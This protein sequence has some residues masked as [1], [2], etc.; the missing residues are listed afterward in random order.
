MSW[1]LPF[2]WP[3]WRA[4]LRKAPVL[5]SLTQDE[6]K[7]IPT[8]H[9][10]VFSYGSLRLLGQGNIGNP[11]LRSSGNHLWLPAWE[12]RGR[13]ARPAGG[14]GR[15]CLGPWTA[16]LRR[17]V[18]VFSGREK[19]SCFRVWGANMSMNTAISLREFMNLFFW[20]DHFSSKYTVSFWGHP[21]GK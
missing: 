6:P 13:F 20:E 16:W 4:G 8:K 12:I 18:R 7:G 9:R 11:C 3:T 14:R 17:C 2:H 10:D 1:Y 19:S 5:E 15:R 21:L